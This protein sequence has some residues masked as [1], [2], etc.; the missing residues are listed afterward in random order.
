MKQAE[1]AHNLADSKRPRYLPSGY[2]NWILL[3]W[4]GGMRKKLANI[5]KPVRDYLY[6]I[7]HKCQNML[8]AYS[9]LLSGEN[10]QLSFL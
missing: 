10:D 2:Q 4:E 5:F 3:L 1:K 9:T 6:I 8:Y 7:Y